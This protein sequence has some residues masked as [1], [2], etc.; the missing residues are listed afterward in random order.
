VCI[1]RVYQLNVWRLDGYFL[2]LPPPGV[3]VYHVQSLGDFLTASTKSTIASEE[4]TRSNTSGIHHPCVR[5]SMRTVHVPDPCTS[6]NGCLIRCT[7]PFIV[8][9][10]CPRGTHLPTRNTYHWR[11]TSSEQQQSRD[12]HLHEDTSIIIILH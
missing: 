1:T 8:A 5:V 2:T 4:Q 7:L 12:N 6:R 3:Y 11:D 9:I 10:Y